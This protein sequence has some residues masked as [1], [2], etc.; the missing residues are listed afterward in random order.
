MGGEKRSRWGSRYIILGCAWLWGF[1]CKPLENVLLQWIVWLRNCTEQAL[2][3][4]EQIN[5]NF[6]LIKWSSFDKLISVITNF[7]RTGNLGLKFDWIKSSQ[8]TRDA[9]SSTSSR[10]QRNLVHKHFDVREDIIHQLGKKFNLR[11][12]ICTPIRQTFRPFLTFYQPIFSFQP[13][14]EKR[15]KSWHLESD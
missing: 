15:F 2:K 7:C 4:F 1:K 11:E 8:L 3:G 10:H 14:I 13:K 9:I 6:G 5:N 12:D